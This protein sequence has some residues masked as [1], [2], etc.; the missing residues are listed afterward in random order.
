MA[1]PI[2]KKIAASNADDW[3]KCEVVPRAAW[4][5]MQTISISID[6]R[7]VRVIRARSRRRCCSSLVYQAIVARKIAIEIA[8]FIGLIHGPH[9]GWM[10]SPLVALG[11]AL[12]GA[13]CLL[14]SWQATQPAAAK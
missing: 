4:P 14:L 1:V 5:T 6:P 11:Y 13:V 8:N 10:V 2:S 3:L 7:I 9:L 12:F